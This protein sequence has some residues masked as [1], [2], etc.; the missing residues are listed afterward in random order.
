MIVSNFEYFVTL[1]SVNNLNHETGRKRRLEHNSGIGH[2]DNNAVNKDIK[3]RITYS[4]NNKT[5]K[6][7]TTWKAIL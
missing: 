1:L 4:A 3:S 7:M 5:V 6:I 2:V